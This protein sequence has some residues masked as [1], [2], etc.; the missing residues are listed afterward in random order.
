MKETTLLM[1]RPASPADLEAI[2]DIRYENDIAGESSPPPRGE[3]PSYLSHLRDTGTLLVAARDDQILGY[4]GV[5]VRGEI[6]FLTDLFIRPGH[7]SG[8]IGQTLLKAVLP[9]DQTKRITLSSTDPR[10]LALY[11]RLGMA[12]RWPNFLMWLD[13]DQIGTLPASGLDVIEAR[14]DDPIVAELDGDVSGRFRPADI[15]YWVQREAATP[16][17]FQRCGKLVGYGFARLGG[18][19]L[20]TAGAAVIGPVGARRT[21]DAAACVIAAIAWARPRAPMIEVAAPGAHPALAPL[22]EA[23]FRIVYVETYCASAADLVDP[24][25][26]V[27][28]GGDLF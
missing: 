5:V 9:S 7:Q 28:S 17:L 25:R 19:R 24:T 22:L 16:L 13:S 26:Y 8:M 18:G 11:A 2:W 14:P 21:E 20:W 12:P 4:A 15:A 23:R 27:G 6:A 3:V 1:V 10:A